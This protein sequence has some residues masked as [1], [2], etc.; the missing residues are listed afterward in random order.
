[1]CGSLHKRA[2]RTDLLCGGP[3]PAWYG[4]RRSAIRFLRNSLEYLA[5]ALVGSTGGT[6]GSLGYSRRGAP[7]RGC[8]CGEGP[9]CPRH[10]VRPAVPRHRDRPARQPPDR[11]AP[12][13]SAA[14][15]RGRFPR[16]TVRA[17]AVPERGG[18]ST[19]ECPARKSLCSSARQRPRRAVRCHS[20][21]LSG[22]AGRGGDWLTGS[23]VARRAPGRLLALGSH[24]T[25]AILRSVSSPSGAGTRGPRGASSACPRPTFRPAIRP[26]SCRGARGRG[27]PCPKG[28]L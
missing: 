24:R 11:R 28:A 9:R 17:R 13:R 14:A 20:P 4:P 22:R 23:S 15:G 7:V 27:L 5:E 3:G 25:F 18:L 1:M 6:A 19:A 26:L 12:R 10:R 2:A 21:G 8:P 16:G